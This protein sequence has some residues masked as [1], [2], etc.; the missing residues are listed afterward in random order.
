MRLVTTVR[1]LLYLDNVSV[2]LHV[3]RVRNRILVVVD[4]TYV[5]TSLGFNAR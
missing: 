2:R 5:T 4:P 3:P 1:A